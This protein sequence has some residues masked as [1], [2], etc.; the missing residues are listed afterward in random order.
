MQKILSYGEVRL[1]LKVE[2][3]KLKIKNCFLLHNHLIWD[4]FS[5][6]SIEEKE[7]NTPS[8]LNILFNCP[9][10]CLVDCDSTT[11][12]IYHLLCMLVSVVVVYNSLQIAD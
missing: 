1:R 2:K 3:D 5:K 9:L 10:F 11:I 4:L 7:I 8:R 6:S 12:T